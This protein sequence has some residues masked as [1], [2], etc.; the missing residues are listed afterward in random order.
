MED[1]IWLVIAAVAMTEALLFE[2]ER[3]LA[4]TFAL[5]L[6]VVA[7]QEILKRTRRDQ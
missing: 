1:R 2:F 5:A 3:A 7:V 6:L 4:W